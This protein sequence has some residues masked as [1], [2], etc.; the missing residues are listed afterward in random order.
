[1]SAL[2]MVT[3]PTVVTNGVLEG[4]RDAAAQLSG[5]SIDTNR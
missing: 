3:G 4:T 1:M 5:Q 2:L